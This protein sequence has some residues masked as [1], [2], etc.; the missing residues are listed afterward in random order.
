MNFANVT[1]WVIPQGNVTKV[2][3]S[4]N[5]II[6][7]KNS[8][9]YTEPFYVENITQNNESLN[10]VVDS[11]LYP[12]IPDPNNISVTVEYS[13]DNVTWNTL[14][15]TSFTPL[16]RTLSPGDKVYLRSNTPSWGYVKP[17]TVNRW[18]HKITGVS[19]V[20]GNIMSLLYG[21]SFV[22]KT[23]APAHGAY[24]T[25]VPIYVSDPSSYKASY[26]FHG[27]FGTNT[28]LIDASELVLPMTTLEYW[29]YTSMFGGCTNLVYPPNELPATTLTST[30]YRSMFSGCSSML[31]A[32]TISAYT[33]AGSCCESM[34]RGCSSLEDAPDLLATDLS[35]ACYCKMF[36]D[37]TNLSY[38]KCLAINNIN[39]NESTLEWLDGTAASG[40]FF[41]NSN[42]TWPTGSNGIPSG[43]TVQNN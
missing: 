28:N 29:A 8:I 5:R 1:D 20:G 17:S 22:G 34:F 9:D 19:K 23:K 18:N 36:K 26:T 27:L 37:C 6:W 39:T 15:T 33:L 31:Y 2:V 40:T 4:Q 16:T 41:K 30:C 14:G 3:D 24:Y 7:Q 25:N 21:S 42:A 13:T 11:A 35:T 10:I 38:V 43:W 32:P 12:E